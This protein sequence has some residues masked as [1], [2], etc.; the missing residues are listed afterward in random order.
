MSDPERPRSPR[1]KARRPAAA[2]VGLV[3]AWLFAG[4]AMAADSDVPVQRPRGMVAPIDT[5]TPAPAP[6]TIEPPQPTPTTPAEAVP[7]P[8][9][10]TPPS[11]AAPAP[12]P[13]ASGTGE[14]I[15]RKTSKRA[16][17]DFR[18]NGFVIDAR[19]G[20]LGC[21]RALCGSGSHDARPGVRLDGFLGGNVKG[22]VDLGVGGGWGTMT[23]RV[24][25]GTNALTLYG[26]DPVALQQALNL[27]GGQALGIDLSTLAVTDA[28]L[29]TAQFGPVVRLHFVP[30]GR[31]IGYVGTGAQ[32][33]LFRAKYDTLGGDVRLDFHGLTVPIQA[34]FGV[35]VLENLAVGIQFDYLWSWYGLST[36]DHP[37]Q[38]FTLPMRVL[39]SAAKMQ[40]VDLRKQMPHFWTFGFALRARI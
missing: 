26:L 10:A 8:A 21:V 14:P 16:P 36:V 15:V 31:F 27:L 7:P 20:T 3:A 29:R 2:C 40:Q 18:H 24:A 38:R 19:V 17:K 37:T 22:W 6:A 13:R 32:Y 23:P 9:A 33:S 12:A 5:P 1:S 34:G 25:E 35:H 39:Q 28:K 4:E 30:R 11:A